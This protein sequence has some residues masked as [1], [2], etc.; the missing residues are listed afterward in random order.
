MARC[1]QFI[2][3]AFWFV[4]G[5][6]MLCGLRFQLILFCVVFAIGLGEFVPRFLRDYSSAAE[7]I[8]CIYG[9]ANLLASLALLVL[10]VSFHVFGLS[11]PHVRP[12]LRSGARTGKH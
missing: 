6:L 3:L 8:A 11:F 4:L 12:N 10:C 9:F 2:A 5:S 1:Q 7:P